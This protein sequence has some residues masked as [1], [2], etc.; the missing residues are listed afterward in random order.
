MARFQL[1]KYPLVVQEEILRQIDACILT[2]NSFVSTRFKHLLSNV[3]IHASSI[4]YKVNFTCLAIE[5]KSD[6]WSLLIE[7]GQF[8]ERNWLSNWKINQIPIESR[9]MLW[10]HVKR[11]IWYQCPL[12]SISEIEALENLDI[13][14]RSFL[15]VEKFNVVIR[16]DP[17]ELL[18][19]FFWKKSLT[20]D[21]IIVDA[22]FEEGGRNYRTVE[23]TPDHLKF[24][25]ESAPNELHLN[26]GTLANRKY[27]IAQPIPRI[28]LL[29]PPM[30]DLS[31]I[32]QSGIESIKCQVDQNQTEVIN[33]VIRKWVQGENQK[34]E[35]LEFH[36]S[37][38]CLLCPGLLT[39]VE[40]ELQPR[41]S[42]EETIQM[43][44]LQPQDLIFEIARA[45]DGRRAAL[46]L[47]HQKVQ[48]L[49]WTD[50]RI[51]EVE[52]RRRDMIF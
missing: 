26:V 39:D 6:K 41:F 10:D 42:S 51:A 15:K 3:K 33:Q 27:E 52:R 20:F 12:T 18:D 45:T 32:L 35:C 23:M 25:E 29:N 2:E 40:R 49:V 48:I 44:G 13:H 47:N 22:Q 5:V 31:N 19:F 11:K 34:L 30:I 24:L 46:V 50:R 37:E 28:H 4:T 14:L 16:N 9:T 43:F 21:K 7:V 36:T 8:Q 1:L 17:P 38:G